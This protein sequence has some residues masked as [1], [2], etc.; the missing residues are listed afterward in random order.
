[1][2]YASYKE[3]YTAFYGEEMEEDSGNEMT[4]EEDSGRD[5]DLPF[6]DNPI[7]EAEAEV[8]SDECPVGGEFGVDFDQLENCNGCV[9]YDNCYAVAQDMVEP[10]PEPEPEPPKR[11]PLRRKAAEAP[12]EDSEPKRKPKPSL[13]RRQA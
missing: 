4:I 10:E 13:R 1:M 7:G 9:N 2:K 8:A 3:L 11:T 5:Q 12:V 6:D